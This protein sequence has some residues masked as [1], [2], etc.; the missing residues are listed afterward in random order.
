MPDAEIVY[1][2]DENALGFAKSPDLEWMPFVGARDWIV[3]SRDR[4]I[5][6]R[7]AELAAYWE[8]GIQSV[9]LGA[10][11]D[12]TPHDQ[13]AMFNKHEIRLRRLA[14]KLGPGPW[15]VSLTVSGVRQ[16]SVKPPGER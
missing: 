12:L 6:S 2:A 8:N 14:I 9:R 7:P 13:V 11:K 5:R 10:K 1:F 3:L 16:M 15:A 4:R